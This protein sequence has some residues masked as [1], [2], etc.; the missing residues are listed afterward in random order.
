MLEFTGQT[1]PEYVEPKKYSALD[2]FFLKLII[3]KRDLPFCYLTLKV[4]LILIPL[5]VL[6]FMPFINGWLWALIAL[7]YFYFNNVALKGPFGLMFH[8]TN[9]RPFFKYDWMNLYLPWILAPFFGQ[10]PMTYHGH[11]IGMHHAEGNL[12]DD[13]STTMPYQRDNGWH[14]L[15]Y[16]F[17]FLFTG[18]GSLGSYFYKKKRMRLFRRVIIGELLFFSL[19]IALC[20]YNWQATVM[21]FILPLVIFRLV[22][23]AGNWVQH[24]FVSAN[25][26]ENPYKNSVTCINTH[27]NHKCWNDGYHI[28]HHIDPNMHW[29]DHPKFF[30]D[31]LEDF[32]KNRAV[33]FNDLTY[34]NIFVYLLKDNYEK[35]AEHFVD[36]G[37][38]FETDEEVITFLR[39][40]MKPVP[41]ESSKP[42]LAV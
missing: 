39:S 29:T 21:V 5:G 4:T 25:E 27:F 14:F 1:D 9:H 7:V 17:V 22:A 19:C 33:V 30:R 20:F 15:H 37:N 8:C 18:I 12:E 3:D 41:F 35:L 42:Q 10:S 2:R 31:H 26:P 16:Y 11:H 32:G 34:V 13:S 38:N 28:S 36:V 23:M 24:A 40:R 6:L